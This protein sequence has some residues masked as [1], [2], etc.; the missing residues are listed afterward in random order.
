MNTKYNMRN[1]HIKFSMTVASKICKIDR[2][3]WDGWGML[4]IDDIDYDSEIGQNNLC[5]KLWLPDQPMA[6]K[7]HMTD[8]LS[9]EG[10]L[11]TS[12]NLLTK[13][14]GFSFLF[15]YDRMNLKME[16]INK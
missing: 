6:N 5:G 2:L 9:P 16:N 12:R 13:H 3:D 4:D 14:R 11:T 7:Y 8:H 1:Q 10:S 15:F